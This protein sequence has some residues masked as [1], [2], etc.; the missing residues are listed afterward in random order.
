MPD[1]VID[2]DPG[3]TVVVASLEFWNGIVDVC[4]TLA[5]DFGTDTKEYKTWIDIASKVEA[6]AFQNYVEDWDAWLEEVDDDD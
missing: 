5:R 3:E 2:V 4:R 1:L 6:Q